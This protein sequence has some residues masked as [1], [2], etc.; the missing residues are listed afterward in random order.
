[1]HLIRETGYRPSVMHM[2][3]L[4][5]PYV[6]TFSISMMSLHISALSPTSSSNCVN[7]GSLPESA[8]RLLE[9][10]LA[11]ACYMSDQLS[12]IPMIKYIMSYGV[13]P[14]INLSRVVHNGYTEAVRILTAHTDKDNIDPNLVTISIMK[15]FP[16][17]LRIL[18]NSGAYV[19]DLAVEASVRYGMWVVLLDLGVS[20]HVYDSL[21]LKTAVNSPCAKTVQALLEHGANPFVIPHNWNT[22]WK[23]SRLLN[24]YRD[25]L[26]TQGQ[27]PST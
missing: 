10:T 9:W 2:H 22:D 15:R 23:T 14:G 11:Q 4:R 17:I 3:A 21:L 26:K 19:D 20:V 5:G 16:D 24:A 25:K 1:M 7:T 12:A 6:L 18:V 8:Y 13:K 27:G